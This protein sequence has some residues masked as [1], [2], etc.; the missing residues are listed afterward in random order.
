M[1][2]WA[3]EISESV[4]SACVHVWKNAVWNVVRRKLKKEARSGEWGAHLLETP[5]PDPQSADTRDG[6]Y[7]WIFWLHDLLHHQKH[8]LKPE[9]QVRKSEEPWQSRVCRPIWQPLSSTLSE[10]C[11]F[12]PLL[13]TC[14]V[15]MWSKCHADRF[16]QCLP[17]HK[18]LYFHTP[19]II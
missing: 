18:F 3:V 7:T 17:V 12:C 14:S 6:I 5:T 10:S 8:P 1:R 2:S 11:A 4:I 19:T 9:F 15:F 16:V 13:A